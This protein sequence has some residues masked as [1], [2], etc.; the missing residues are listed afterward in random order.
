M[1]PL[2]QFDYLHIF[3]NIYSKSPFRAKNILNTPQMTNNFH[4]IDVQKKK[5][6]HS[7]H[8]NTSPVPE[9]IEQLD[10]FQFLH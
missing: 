10:K 2:T 9:K 5:N 1:F 4:W 7:S 3:H 6:S 8:L